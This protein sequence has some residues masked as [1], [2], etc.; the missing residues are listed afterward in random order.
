MAIAQL[1]SVNGEGLLVERRSLTVTRQ[2]SIQGCPVIKSNNDKGVI[3]DQLFT[4][5]G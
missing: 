3:I 1:L 4:V 2:D 5:H